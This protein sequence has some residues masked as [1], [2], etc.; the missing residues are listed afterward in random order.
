MSGTMRVLAGICL[1]ASFLLGQD[2]SK[3]TPEARSFVELH[4]VAAKR[5]EADSDFA[6]AIDEYGQILKKYPKLVPAVYQNL[7]LVYY[8]ARKYEA[9]IETLSEGVRLDPSMVG[10]RLFLGTAYLDTEQPVKALPHLEYAY[11]QKPT[12]ESA[13]TLGLAY[14]GL[15]QYDTAARYFRLGLEGSEQKDNQ[16]YFIA[17]SYLKLSE[18]EANILAEQN[19]DSKYDHLLAAKVLESQDRYQMAAKEYLAAGKKDPFNAAIFFPLARMLAIL[20]LDKPAGTALERYQQLM[21]VD[22][23]A[24]LDASKLPKGQSADVGPRTDYEGDLKALPPVDSRGLPPLPQLN[25]DVNAELWKR[26][27]SDSP[28]KWKAATDHLLHARWREGIAALEGIPQSDWL[29]DYLIATA[30]LWSDEYHKAEEV[31]NHQALKS[32]TSP[33]VQ[34]LGWSVNEQL[35]FLYFSRLLEEFPNSARGH[36]L[37]GRTLDA[38]GNKDAEAEYQAAIAADPSQSE[39]RIALADFYLSNSKYQEALS[40]CQK[41]LEVNNYFSPAKLRIGRIYI[42]LRDPQKGIPYIQSVLKM[43]PDDAQARADLARGLELLG[44]V[45]KAVAEYQR[46][47]ALDPALNRIHY[48]LGRIYRKQGKAELADNEFRVFAKNEAS[49][50]AKHLTVGKQIPENPADEPGPPS[51]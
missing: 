44:E 25:S 9:A 41:T 23:R 33:S 1:M 7:G 3:L 28:A 11:K 38:Q 49:E 30:Y 17:D 22:Q 40:E 20:G 47:L 24:A 21:V 15:R 42:Q 10:A 32:Q 8:V 4:F 43:E 50:R 37:K 29:R 27:A 19:P 48:V 13:T 5:A 2:P 35:S 26:L 36:Y 31:L 6:K 39:A 51:H 34:M 16:L 12:T 14:S 18:R 45:D 46:A